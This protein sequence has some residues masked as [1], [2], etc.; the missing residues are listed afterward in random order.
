[1]R[2]DKYL[3]QATGRSRAQSRRLIRLGRV[4]VRGTAVCDPAARIADEAPVC[5]D[6]AT[7]HAHCAR[8]FM[9]HK[10]AG[11]V[12]TQA[13][14]L[15]RTIFSLLNEPRVEALHAAGRLDLD[16][17]GLVLLTDDG[18][19]SH[20]VTAPRRKAAKCYDV[21]LAEPVD[22]T[23]VS[24]LRN[25]LLLRGETKPT[26]A[27]ELDLTGECRCRLTLR[28]GRYH[29]VKRMFAAVGNRVVALHRESIGDV[30][31]DPALAPGH[32]RALTAS[33]IAGFQC[34]AESII[35]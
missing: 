35:L 30:G 17:T 7:V 20:R 8:Y 26:R 12:C 6:G 2:L 1:M 22:A 18:R 24:R 3:S 10:P 33:E 28:E 14:P 11:V 5:L 29:Q 32:Y 9:V 31:L 16:T 25:G 34:S 19:W 21:I 23:M 13:D 4:T 27:C 15:H